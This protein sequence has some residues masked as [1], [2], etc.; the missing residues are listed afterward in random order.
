MPSDVAGYFCIYE[1][2]LQLLS[3]LHADWANSVASLSVSDIEFLV[4]YFDACPRVGID[5]NLEQIVSEWFLGTQNMK[6]I[7]SVF[8]VV[9]RL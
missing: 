6:C 5:S 3:T 8:R 2:V 1:D 4:W 7:V 9:L